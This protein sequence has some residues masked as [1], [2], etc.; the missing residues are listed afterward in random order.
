LLE[1]IV[2]MAIFLMSI[3]VLGQLVTMGGERALDID[4]QGEAG[5]LAQSKMSEVIWGAVPLQST[6][7]QAFDEAPDYKWSMTADQNTTVANLWNVTVTVTRDRSD[8]TKV[9]SVLSQMILDPSQR[10][11]S[12]DTVSISGS[13][14]TGGGGAASSAAGGQSGG[15][16]QQS[17]QGGA[18]AAAQSKG[19]APGSGAA[20]KTGKAGAGTTPRANTPSSA[21]PKTT[22][23]SSSAPKAGAPASSSPRAG[24]K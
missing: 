11:S 22:V 21:A 18:A 7:D 15:Q 2:A 10:G 9:E 19:T 17:M 14:S 1:V 3:V 6:S 23:P 13:P 5:L 16:Q 8:G 24:G 4:Q 12:Q 20:S